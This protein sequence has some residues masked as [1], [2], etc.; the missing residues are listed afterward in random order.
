MLCYC[1]RIVVCVGVVVTY[2]SPA[3]SLPSSLPCLWLFRLRR[4]RTACPC[5]GCRRQLALRASRQTTSSTTTLRASLVFRRAERPK[6]CPM[7]SSSC[8]SSLLV[9][10][11]VVVGVVLP[12][13][14][15]QS[16]RSATSMK[17]HAYAPASA[18]TS[19]SLLSSIATLLPLS[20]SQS[21][22]PMNRNDI[23]RGH[24]HC[25]G[26]RPP[27]CRCRGARRCCDNRAVEDPICQAEEGVVYAGSAPLHPS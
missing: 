20:P 2:V 1:L 22:R 26:R 19:L 5:R 7:R 23:H 4:I 14:P 6:H 16:W 12:K 3:P 13:Y 25:R 10:V 11:I 18:L 21:S 15:S 27:H 9:S 8:S 17:L 24:H